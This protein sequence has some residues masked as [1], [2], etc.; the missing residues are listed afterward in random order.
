MK[1][2]IAAVLFLALAMACF[3]SCGKSPAGGEDTGGYQVYGV[4]VDGLQLKEI[5]LSLPSAGGDI[6]ASEMAQQ[7]LGYLTTMPVENGCLNAL[8]SDVKIRSAVLEN[9]LLTLDFSAQYRKMDQ[10]KELLCRAAYVQTL[11]Q[12]EGIDMISFTVEKEP[13]LKADGEPVGIMTNETF[14]DNS[15]YSLKQYDKTMMRLYYA[16]ES[17]DAL[18]S[19]TREVRYSKNRPIA[20]SAVL[21]L[22]KAPADPSLKAVVPASARLLGVTT[23]DGICYL[24]FDQGFLSDDVTVND[25]VRIYALVNTVT[26]AAGVSEVQIFINGDSG[27]MLHESIDLSKPFERNLDLVRKQGTEDSLQDE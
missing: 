5:P 1:R 27:V 2:L 3:T 14:V 13:L 18:I 23:R 10:A 17:G 19:E 22:Q 26:E 25:Q 7:F 4:D 12:I 16:N 15:S 9:G 21:Q 11:L 20:E 24:N 6:S 8:P